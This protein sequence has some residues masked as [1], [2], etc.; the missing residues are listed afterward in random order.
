MKWKR[1]TPPETVLFVHCSAIIFSVA[2]LGYSSFGKV[3]LRELLDGWN[4]SCSS[5][6]SRI[7][8]I[9]DSQNVFIF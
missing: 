6:H 7:N 8:Y 2:F 4:R 5:I 1:F 3:I 9:Q